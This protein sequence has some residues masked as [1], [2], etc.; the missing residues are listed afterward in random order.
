MFRRSTSGFAPVLRA[1]IRFWISVESLKRPPTLFTMPS[2]FS[3]SSML[4]PPSSEFVANDGFQRVRGGGQFR[5]DQHA[6]VLVL[7]GQLVRGGVQPAAD[8]LGRLAAAFQPVH[9]VVERRWDDEDRE[10]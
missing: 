1:T 3:S 8:R 4:K 5:V 6:V 9:Q 2:S 10:Q 7:S